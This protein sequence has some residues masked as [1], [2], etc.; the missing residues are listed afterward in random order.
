[1][2]DMMTSEVFSDPIR[3]LPETDITCFDEPGRYRAKPVGPVE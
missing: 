1:M 3:K 2:K